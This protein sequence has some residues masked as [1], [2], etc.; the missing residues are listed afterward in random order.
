MYYYRSVVC[1]EEKNIRKQMDILRDDK[2]HPKTDAIRYNIVRN[3]YD[4]GKRKNAAAAAPSDHHLPPGWTRAK[5]AEGRTYF[6]N[7]KNKT[8]TVRLSSVFTHLPR[9]K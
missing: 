4:M 7:T 1:I 3:T 8:T 2:K 9:R 5:T 6:I